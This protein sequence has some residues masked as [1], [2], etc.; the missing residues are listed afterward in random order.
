LQELQLLTNKNS[1]IELN[2]LE[3]KVTELSSAM[4]NAESLLENLLVHLKSANMNPV[5]NYYW[6]I[7]VAVYACAYYFQ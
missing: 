1:E 5:A 2:D 6:L 3:Y 7:F 4:K